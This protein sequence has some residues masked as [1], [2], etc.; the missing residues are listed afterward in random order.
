MR[1]ASTAAA[2]RKAA[3]Q[4]GTVIPQPEEEFSARLLQREGQHMW[5]DVAPYNRRAR[6]SALANYPVAMEPV[7]N[8]PAQNG[9][10]VAGDVVVDAAR[11]E[12]GWI[13]H[14]Y[15]AGPKPRWT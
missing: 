4:T 14:A 8:S 5:H 7:A 2:H 11:N 6:L 9:L 13:V 10:P 1:I 12:T 3:D 15:R